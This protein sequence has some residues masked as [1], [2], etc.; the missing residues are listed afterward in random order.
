MA[1]KTEELKGLESMRRYAEHW[2][3]NAAPGMVIGLVGEL[4]AGKTTFTH[5]FA[6]ALGY[7]G[8]TGS[9]TFTLSK[10]YRAQWPIYHIDC[11]RLNSIEAFV[12]AGLDAYLPSAD[13]ITLVEWVNKFPQLLPKHAT[14][15]ELAIKDEDTRTVSSFKT[16]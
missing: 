4:G 13:G 15:I 1:K 6:Q 7:T 2:A 14:V 12:Q 3:K 16:E 11:Y 5:F 9:P 8:H 10:C